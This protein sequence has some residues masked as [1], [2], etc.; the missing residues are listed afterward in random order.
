[1]VRPSTFLCACASSVAVASPLALDDE[2]GTMMRAL[3]EFHEEQVPPKPTASPAAEAA[4]SGSGVTMPSHFFADAREEPAREIAPMGSAPP[5]WLGEHSHYRLLP[6][7]FPEGMTYHFDGLAV[8]SQFNFSGTGKATFTMKALHSKTFDHYKECIFFGSGTGPTLGIEPCLTN[9]AVNLLPIH[10]QLWLTIDT[11]KWARID[12]GTLETLP[13]PVDQTSMVLNAHP[14]CDRTTGE[15]FV[16]YPCDAE[17]LNGTG[18]FGK[19]VCMATLRT[20]EAAAGITSDVRGTAELPK[21]K[22]IQHSHSPCVTRS[23]VVS[24]LDSFTPRLKSDSEAGGVLKLMHQDMDNLWLVMDRASNATRILSSVDSATGAPYP[25]INNHFA[26]CYDD[27]TDIVVDTVAVTSDYLDTYFA[28]QLA[29]PTNWSKIFKVPQ[30]CRVPMVGDG[31][32]KCAPLTPEA[33]AG[34]LWD[35]PTFNPTV[36]MLPAGQGYNSLYAI[37]PRSTASQWFDSIIKLDA[38]TGA[39]AKQWSEEGIFV[40]EADVVPRP[41]AT[42]DDDGLLVT[43]LF[44][45]TGDFPESSLALFDAADL[46]LVCRYPLGQVLPFHAHGI[47]CPPGAACYTNP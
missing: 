45:S 11:S 36:K 4:R 14:A 30:R 25:F 19:K 6:G 34:F 16:Q 31:A 29:L 5:A 27:G 21:G 35:Y 13:D 41:G 32:I 26:N 12:A 38:K 24:K 44:N 40:T 2:L 33:P 10:D 17:V 42:A 15:C 22:I 7:H 37:A 28:D 23:S 47:V 43:V 39:V 8:V 20:Q 9:P 18:V 1:M 46:S 3:S